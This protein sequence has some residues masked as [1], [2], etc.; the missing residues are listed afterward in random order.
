MKK[1][2]TAKKLMG[3][4]IGTPVIYSHGHYFYQVQDPENRITEAQFQS[5]LNGG[6]IEEVDPTPQ[7]EGEEI[8][9]I[10]IIRID[11]DTTCLNGQVPA[12]SIEVLA[13][14]HNKLVNFVKAENAR[15]REV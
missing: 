4:P 13:K 3:I 10:R 11:V 5:Q 9:E 1:Y 15:R 7:S 8:E 2:I 14:E 12:D 6:Y